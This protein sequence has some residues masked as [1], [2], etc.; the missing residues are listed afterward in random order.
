VL[1]AATELF[2]RDGYGVTS[3]EAV[4]AVA[5]VSK[6]TLYARFSGKAAL[7]QMVVARLVTNW[8]P[9]FD[10]EVEQGGE[11]RDTLLGSARVMLATAL[12]PQALEL[13]RL[14]IAEIGRFPELALVIRNAGAAAGTERLAKVMAAAGVTDPIWA[15]EQF[16]ALV[17]SVPQRRGLGLGSPLDTA[18][19]EAWAKRAV[20]LFLDGLRI[21]DRAPE[22][23]D[24]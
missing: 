14:I 3:L 20:D 8:L 7:L 19:Q 4:A 18:E 6:R 24:G 23:E 2:L 5:G 13:Y 9:A 21:G 11:L 15:A 12:T 1:D 17:L 10:A 22:A 16:M